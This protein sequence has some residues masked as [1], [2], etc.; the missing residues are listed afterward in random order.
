MADKYYNPKLRIYV[1]NS[2]DKLPSKSQGNLS[3]VK[4]GDDSIAYIDIS[5]NE[6]YPILPVWEELD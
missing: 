4:E 1:A 6:R 3:F 2:T 5:D